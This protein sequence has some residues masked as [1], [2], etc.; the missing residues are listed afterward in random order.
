MDLVH[1]LTHASSLFCELTLL[2]QLFQIV[3]LALL[4]CALKDVFSQPG[5]LGAC[6]THPK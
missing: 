2:G 1:S 3:F 6:F 5:H 4:K